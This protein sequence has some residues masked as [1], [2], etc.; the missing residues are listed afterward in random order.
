MHRAKDMRRYI[1]QIILGIALSFAVMIGVVLVSNARDL[2][3]QL[4]DFPL[5]VFL[6][7]I[8]LKVINWVLRYWEWHY[9]LHII[10]VNP[11]FR[12]ETK[13]ASADGSPA[14]IRMT[15]SFILWMAS[16]PFSLSPGKMAEV[17]KALILKSMTGTPV[18]RS[19]PII[20]AERLIDGI[21]VVLI[22][23]TSAL[24]APY[25]IFSTDDLSLHSIRLIL[26]G[27]T[28]FMLTAIAAAQSK[29]IAYFFIDLISGVALIG[30]FQ[31]EIRAL[32][33]SSYHLT[34]LKHLFRTTSFGLGAY[35]SDCLGFYLILLGL[36]EAASWTLFV[37]A[38][39]ILGF[40]VVVSAISAM[41]GG[42]GGREITI[43]LMLSGV[44]GMSEGTTGAAVLMIGIFQVWFGAFL[45]ILI[46]LAFRK[47]LFPPALTSEIHAYE[48]QR[49][50]TQQAPASA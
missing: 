5:W 8:G 9:F 37:Q 30:R 40:S 13:A 47:R 3:T 25:A 29:R 42:A 35:L 15:D 16:L 19:T 7:V 33:D 1:S 22:V 31:S 10:K 44:V 36:G 21:A 34:K 46:G 27:T 43:G 39:F 32:Y 50:D 11:V 18:V 49:Q 20:F 24:I 23:G 2:A 26:I 41:P 4:G 17:L 48:Q 12:G 28:F 14:T 45:G 6:P 38:T